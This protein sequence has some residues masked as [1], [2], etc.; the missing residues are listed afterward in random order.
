MDP[1]FTSRIVSRLEAQG[2][3]SRAQNVSARNNDLIS[4]RDPRLLLDAWRARYEFLRHDVIRGHVAAR[5][6]EELVRELARRFADSAI[7]YAATGLS[8]AWLRTH[9]AG[10]RLATFYL[11]EAPEEDFLRDLGFREDPK[12]PNVWLVVPN[13]EG[14]F[15][16]A[17][18]VEDIQCVHPV[19]LYVDLKDH[20]ERSAE[21]A[22]QLRSHLFRASNDARQN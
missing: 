4:V 5:T 10:F 19:Q 2:F 17:G 20:P 18:T 1:G 11:G 6:S 14:V 21:A 7:D 8:A 16:G 13:D 12:G 9:F 22:E 15:E 3:V